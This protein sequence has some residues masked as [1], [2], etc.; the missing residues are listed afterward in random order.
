MIINH[1]VREHIMRMMWELIGQELGN[2]RRHDNG[3]Q[4]II[5]HDPNDMVGSYNR[6]S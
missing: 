1:E 4:A 5:L 3:D 2:R 6:C